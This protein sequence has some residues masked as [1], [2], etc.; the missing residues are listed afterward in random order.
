MVFDEG[1]YDPANEP[2][3]AYA[4]LFQ[5]LPGRWRAAGNR[6]LLGDTLPPPPDGIPG[7][8][9]DTGR[10]LPWAVFTM[11]RL[12]PDCPERTILYT[13][14]PDIRPGEIEHGAGNAGDR[15]TARS[16]IDR[17]TLGDRR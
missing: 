2:D 6:R 11:L 15:K 10:C 4:Y 17:M 7:S 5:P 9:D 16:Y 13:D 8:S 12:Y 3:I 1:L 14:V